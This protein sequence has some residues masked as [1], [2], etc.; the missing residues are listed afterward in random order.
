[1][2]KYYQLLLFILSAVSILCFVFYKHE[3]DRLR[4]VLEVLDFFGPSVTEPIPKP[5]FIEAACVNGSVEFIPDFW[6]KYDNDVEIY[7]AFKIANEKGWSINSVAVVGRDS[8]S[9]LRHSSC[10]LISGDVSDDKFEGTIEWKKIENENN[11]LAAYTVTC[12]VP[13]MIGNSHLFSLYDSKVT[14]QPLNIPLHLGP[15]HP[16]DHATSLCVISNDPY[17]HTGD[18]VDFIQYYTLLG[19][20]NFYLYHRGIGDQVI[21]ALKALVL[22]RGNVTVHLAMWNRQSSSSLLDYALISHDCAWRHGAK[23][24]P[25]VTVHF[26]HFLVLSKG[27]GLKEFLLQLRGHGTESSY[28]AR[29]PLHSICSNGTS[30]TENIRLPRMI[31]PKRKQFK[32]GLVRWTE[33]PNHPGNP[34]TVKIDSHMAKLLIFESCST[35]SKAEDDPFVRRFNAIAQDIPNFRKIIG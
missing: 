17:W 4:K 26:G 32:T 16:K 29:I 19:V 11:S 33:A 15:T 30:G 9:A 21:S 22:T 6:H 18:L 27:L 7:A 8:P 13:E 24:G 35:S 3:Y 31:N 10:A 20:D 34:E 28:E 23:L 5:E 2:R 25:A 12:N 1:M 14:L